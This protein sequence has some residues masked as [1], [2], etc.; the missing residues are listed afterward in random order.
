M[1]YLTTL[2]IEWA[3]SALEWLG[4]KKVRDRIIRITLV[5][6]IFGVILSTMHQ[7]S[8]GGL[9]LISPSKVHPL[10]Y[11]SHLPIYFFISSIPAG[12]S[13]VI[14]V[15]TLSFWTLRDRM[16][17]IY[18]E[19][20]N[21]VTIGFAKAAAFTLAGYFFI[22]LVGISLDNNWHYLWTGWGAWYLFELLG[23]VA[24]PAFL[25]AI[26]ARENNQK[27]ICWSAL[28]CVLGVILNRFNVTLVAFNWQLPAAE[29]YFPSWMEIALTIY[30]ITLGVLVFRYI[31]SLMPI[32][33]EHPKFKE[34]VP[35]EYE[36]EEPREFE[37][38][39][40]KPHP[41]TFGH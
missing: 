20:R 32:Y 9:Y 14:L 7:S 35:H 41:Q 12:F 26:G 28:L 18:L 29:R 16:D 36:E 11:S 39:K 8:F 23:F 15:D 27:L 25:F 22:K 38:H 17:P 6:T 5:L 34:H 1:L 31:A 40:L 30:Q 37:E 4:I 10:W 13:M 24:L 19:E 2:F 3:P 21:Q 33:F